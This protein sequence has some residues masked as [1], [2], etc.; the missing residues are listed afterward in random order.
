M[1]LANQAQQVTL[2]WA[3]GHPPEDDTLCFIKV[4]TAGFDAVFAALK[5]SR[6][7]EVHELFG[8]VGGRYRQL[9]RTNADHRA[10]LA[11]AVDDDKALHVVF[12]G[13]S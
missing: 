2:N 12:E 5:A 1:P 13:E 8:S 7:R 3:M 10:A 6:S 4:T 11:A 9:D